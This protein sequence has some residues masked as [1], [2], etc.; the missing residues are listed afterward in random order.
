MSTVDTGE[1][2]GGIETIRRGIHHSPEL[3]QGIGVTLTLA[4]I[5]S[6]G[7]VIVPIAVPSEIVISAGRTSITV[8]VSFGSNTVSPRIG[9]VIVCDVT[10]TAKMRL[11]LVA[12]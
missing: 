10:P 11:P 12:V 1:Q 6:L 4:I 5:A 9:T 2:L 8:K 7:Q 3:V